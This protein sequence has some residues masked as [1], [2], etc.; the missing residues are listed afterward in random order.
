MR[1]PMRPRGVWDAATCSEG[2][3]V[4]L[5]RWPVPQLRA[6]LL[7]RGAARAVRDLEP[8]RVRLIAERIRFF[9]QQRYQDFAAV[10]TATDG[11]A[12]NGD[13]GAHCAGGCWSPPQFS[14][15]RSHA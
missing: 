11:F 2:E 9:L 3:N 4:P 6:R 5:R 8:S 14:P 13:V 1:A 12:R 15:R 10:G 7:Q